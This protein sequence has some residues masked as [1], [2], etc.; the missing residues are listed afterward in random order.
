METKNT[1]QTQQFRDDWTKIQL[2]SYDGP[3]PYIFISYSHRDT[4]QVYE[5]LKIIDREKYRYWYDDTMEIGEDFREELRYRIENC[6]AF[7]LFL[8]NSALQSKY[9]GMEIITAFKYDKRIFPVYLDD[10]VEIPPALKMI[11]EN[12]QHVKGVSKQTSDKYI[13]KLVASLPIETMR[14]L[15]SEGDV[16]TRCKDGSPSISIPSGIK[17]IGNSAFKN[18]DKLEK[19]ELGG[20]VEILKREAFRG[21]KS[22]KEVHL[23]KNVRKIG[24]SV[25]RDCISMTSLTVECAEMELG[26]RAFENCATLENIELCDGITEIYGGAFNSCK[27]LISINLPKQL[28]IVGESAFADCARLKSINIPEHVTKLDDMVFNGC[29]ELE[30]VNLNS[31][32]SII[33]KNC[34]KDCMSLRALKIPASVKNIGSGIFRGCTALESIEVDPKNKWYKSLDNIL[35]NK[36]KS[37]I[38]CYPAKNGNH[39]YIIPDSVT[40]ISDWAFCNTSLKNIEIP[41]SVCNIGEGAFYSCTEIEEIVIPDSVTRI[42]DSAFRGCASLKFISIPDSV[43]EFGWGLFSGCDQVTVICSKHSAA[44]KYCENKNIPHREAK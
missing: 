8:S 18:C 6:S 25:F 32:V 15:Q 35:F 16:L 34:F 29:T 39:S 42:D 12:L 5:V 44:A 31:E 13:N 30:E 9:C 2:D 21:C 41:D 38:V 37:T 11:L 19:I 43:L 7:L 28:T 4:A 17:V 40:V 26:E 20:E 1:E 10:D 24:E 36:N 3:E 23:P 27:A 14:S 33:G 22:L